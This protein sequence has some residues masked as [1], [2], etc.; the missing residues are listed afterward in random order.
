[1][2]DTFIDGCDDHVNENHAKLSWS[3][4]MTV[5]VFDHNYEHIW[6]TCPH[7]S[8]W[9]RLRVYNGENIAFSEGLDVESEPTGAAVWPEKTIVKVETVPAESQASSITQTNRLKT[10]RFTVEQ[11]LWLSY[12]S[13]PV[14]EPR[15]DSVVDSKTWKNEHYKKLVCKEKGT[16]GGQSYS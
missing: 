1:M 12:S 7:L 5:S 16:T 8:N 2:S 13:H 6:Q 4:K 9:N 10:F 14:P 3:K 11:V 15:G